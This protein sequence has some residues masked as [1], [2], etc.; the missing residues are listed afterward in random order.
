MGIKKVIYLNSYAEYKG[1][2]TDEGVDFLRR[3]GVQVEKFK[4][5]EQ[6]VSIA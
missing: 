1:I 6:L 5:P 2:G 4:K 3:F